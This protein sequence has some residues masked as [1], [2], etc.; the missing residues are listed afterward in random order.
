MPSVERSSSCKH[1][2]IFWQW[3]RK[4][5]TF[6]SQELKQKFKQ[7]W[8]NVL[9]EWEIWNS[10]KPG[11]G[12]VFYLMVVNKCWELENAAPTSWSQTLG[13]FSLWT[14]FIG[15]K[16]TTQIWFPDPTETFP[17]REWI[18]QLFLSQFWGGSWGDGAWFINSL[19]LLQ[20]NVLLLLKHWFIISQ[21]HEYFPPK[22]LWCRALSLTPVLFPHF[23]PWDGWT[24]WGFLPPGSFPQIFPCFPEFFPLIFHSFL[25][26]VQG[27]DH[28]WVPL[29]GISWW[30]PNLETPGFQ[31]KAGSSGNI[32][33]SS[34]GSL[35]LSP[36][37]PGLF[38]ECVICVYYTWSLNHVQTSTSS[39]PGAL[40][41]ISTS[42]SPPVITAWSQLLE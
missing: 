40:K 42:H 14:T 12:W 34:S 33:G 39:S 17:S 26:A 30:L 35:I 32:P 41:S 38:S 7:T 4:Y 29:P 6:Q 27:K 3:A 28:G 9:E 2:L 25:P 1:G 22:S 10:E 21:N 36:I 16:K 20:N 18:P 31:P 11:A 19:V 24:L 8:A 5:S 15:W 37:I 23:I 13:S